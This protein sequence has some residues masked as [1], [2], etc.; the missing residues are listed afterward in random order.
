MEFEIDNPI[1]ATYPRVLSVKQGLEILS[2]FHQTYRCHDIQIKIAFDYFKLLSQIFL[3]S[4]TKGEL[5]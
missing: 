1:S 2:L 4:S 3:I 5:H